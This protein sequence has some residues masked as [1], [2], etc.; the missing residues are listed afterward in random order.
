ML[1][2]ALEQM[3]HLDFD[4]ADNQLLGDGLRDQDQTSLYSVFGENKKEIN[5]N[6]LDTPSLK[7]DEI[8]Q[9]LD[10]SSSQETDRNKFKKN[11]LYQSNIQNC[12]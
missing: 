11:K 6:S 9:L 8:N 4:Y 2:L 10:Q 12:N 3:K 5:L 1:Y 7:A